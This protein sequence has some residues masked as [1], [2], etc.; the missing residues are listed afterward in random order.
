MVTQPSWHSRILKIVDPQSCAS[1]N[2]WILRVVDPH[3]STSTTLPIRVKVS[4]LTVE[5]QNPKPNTMGNK[6]QQYDDGYN[7]DTDDTHDDP[8]R[9]MYGSRPSITTPL[10]TLPKRMKRAATNASSPLGLLASAPLR[11]SLTSGKLLTT[12]GTDSRTGTKT[13]DTEIGPFLRKLAPFL[14]I[15]LWGLNNRQ[16]VLPIS[17]GTTLAGAL[18]QATPALLKSTT[19]NVG[20]QG[21]EGTNW[22]GEWTDW[23]WDMVMEAAESEL[24]RLKLRLVLVK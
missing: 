6:T 5:D 8:R 11:T 17:Y 23:R 9:Y 18:A 14:T 20:F 16:T 22:V 21:V 13:N 10:K 7:N 15:D 19:I 3:P 2:L 12:V 24:I 4:P 1:S